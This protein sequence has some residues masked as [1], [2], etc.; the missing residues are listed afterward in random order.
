[1]RNNIKFDEE[2]IERLRKTLEERHGMELSDF[3]QYQI[4]ELWVTNNFK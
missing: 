1:M 2:I 3:N 4:I